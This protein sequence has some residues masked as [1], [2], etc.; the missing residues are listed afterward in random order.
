MIKT[1][2]HIPTTNFRDAFGSV[3]TNVIVTVV[4]ILTN[5]DANRKRV[6]LVIVRGVPVRVAAPGVVDALEFDVGGQVVF[7]VHEEAA[8]ASVP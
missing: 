4:S 5:G 6:D 3:P 7:R 8:A 2:L 1:Y